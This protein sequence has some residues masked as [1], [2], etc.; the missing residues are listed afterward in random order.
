MFC[1]I[2]I[3]HRRRIDSAKLAEILNK[4]SGANVLSVAD[5]YSRSTVY[6]G[7]KSAPGISAYDAGGQCFA[8]LQK[9]VRNQSIFHFEAVVPA[10][11]QT[12]LKQVEVYCKGLQSDLAWPR[13]PW[14]Y[15]VSSIAVRPFENNFNESGFEG[16]LFTL[17][18]ALR[19]TNFTHEI[20][21]K[22]VTLATTFLLVRFQLTKDSRTAAAVTFLIAAAFAL[23]ELFAGWHNSRGKIA[24][25]RL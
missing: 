15:G 11:V 17:R 5:A 24:W 9:V 14:A 4:A 13:A 7:G 25:R 1:E 6:T 10:T 16:S 23:V 20:G 21:T 12:L 2:T 18:Q 22:L 8:I 19:D 3:E